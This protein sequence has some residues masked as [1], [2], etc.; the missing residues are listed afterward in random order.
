MMKHKMTVMTRQLFVF[1][2]HGIGFILHPVRVNVGICLD[3]LIPVA[4]SEQL[5]IEQMSLSRAITFV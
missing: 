4:E 2:S 5:F 1:A 3:Y